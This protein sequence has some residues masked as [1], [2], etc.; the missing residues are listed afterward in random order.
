MAKTSR[1][2]NRLQIIWIIIEAHA[3]LQWIPIWCQMLQLVEHSSI[4]QT[5]PL[6][7][8]NGSSLNCTTI[9]MVFKELFNQ[10][11]YFQ[12]LSHFQINSYVEIKITKRLLR[13]LLHNQTRSSLSL[14][15]STL[16]ANITSFW[17]VIPHVHYT[18]LQNTTYK[19]AWISLKSF[20]LDGAGTKQFSQLGEETL[21]IS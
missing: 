17:E 11:T 21:H 5:W 4:E 14:N 16:A 7:S 6:G 18:S 15:V 19:K 8:V 13:I 1:V 3:T 9:L 12:Y 2:Q 20:S 10:T